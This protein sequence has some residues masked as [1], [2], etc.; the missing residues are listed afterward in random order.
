MT[1]CGIHGIV[2]LLI[3]V[4]WHKNTPEYLIKYFQAL[5]AK[6]NIYAL[7]AQVKPC[8]AQK[9]AGLIGH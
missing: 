9:T 2:S 3:S 8:F 5:F 6:G 7:N 4:N 1:V